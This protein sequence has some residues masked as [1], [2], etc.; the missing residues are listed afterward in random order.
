[1]PYKDP[2]VRRERRRMKYQNTPVEERTAKERDRYHNGGKKAS[3]AEYHQR[4]KDERLAYRRQYYAENREKIL[5]RERI[6][7]IT[8]PEH[9]KRAKLK[10]RYGIT[11]GERDALI[12]EQGHKCAICGGGP[13]HK[14]WHV[15][16]C[17][18]S[19]RVR[20]ILC[21]KCN[22]GLG[23]FRDNEAFL[24]S[25]INYLRK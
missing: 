9:Y 11:F 6:R 18:R 19:G 12:K 13:G 5:E 7:R 25:A 10:M 4:T 8:N 3:M 2:D 16:H 23:N 24:Q 14:G 21:F 15:D 17:H 22:T 1:M 20:G